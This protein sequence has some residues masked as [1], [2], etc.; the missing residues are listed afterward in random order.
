M[1]LI[2]SPEFAKV[3]WD[4][5]LRLVKR[6]RDMKS[7]ACYQDARIRG[8]EQE[9]E[10]LRNQIESDLKGRIRKIRNELMVVRSV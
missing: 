9:N 7:M 5:W 1:E 8:L 2:S 10:R 6:F 4:Q 3:P